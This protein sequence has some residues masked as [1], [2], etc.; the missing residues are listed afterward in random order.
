LIVNSFNGDVYEIEGNTSRNTKQGIRKMKKMIMI[1][2]AISAVTMVQ[3]SSL[4]WNSVG[5][6]DA[7]K[8][9][10]GVAFTS[11][12]GSQTASLMA[13]FI[14]AADA[15]TLTTAGGRAEAAAL[16]K[17]TA[18]GQTAAAATGRMAGSTIVAGNTLAGV[19]Y[20]A[21]VFVTVGGQEYFY[22][23]T[24]WT[25]ASGGTSTLVEALAWTGKGGTQTWTAVVP[26]PTSMALLALGVAAIGLRRKLRK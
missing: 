1:L 9:T 6:A 20:I 10:G 2:A 24:S 3:A 21:R 26:E 8:F 14:L 19:A 25:S 7:L 12:A 13:Y 15:G 5:A 22:N 17:A 11:G 23:T 18:A 16:A 4:R